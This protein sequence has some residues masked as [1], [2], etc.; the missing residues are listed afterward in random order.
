MST[1][2]Q[3]FF[4]YSLIIFSIFAVIVFLFSFSFHYSKYFF[5]R[6]VLCACLSVPDVEPNTLD[7]K[8][9]NRLPGVDT[10]ADWNPE[11]LYSVISSHQYHPT[12]IDCPSAAHEVFHFNELLLS[13]GIQVRR[14]RVFFGSFRSSRRHLHTKRFIFHCAFFEMKKM[15]NETCSKC[16]EINHVF[17][18]SIPYS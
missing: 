10:H 13:I 3:F 2:L 14:F 11:V 6:C 18:H 12:G 15:K 9:A 16:R 17:N 4:S 7:R 1:Y 5:V 8:V